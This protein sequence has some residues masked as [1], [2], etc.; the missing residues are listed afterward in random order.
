MCAWLGVSRS[1]YYAWKNNPMSATAERREQL[2]ERIKDIFADSDETYGY[3]RIHAALARQGVPAGPELVRALMRELGLV[4][5]QPRPWRLTTVPDPTAAATP[6]LVRRD[7]T[8]TAPGAKLVGDIT[9]IKT[10]EGW[11]YLATV[12]DCH[13][14]MVIGY[15]MADHMKT[16][17][18]GDAIDMAARNHRLPAGAIFHSDRGCQYTST[19]F[20]NTLRA[21]RIRP[22]VGRTG[23]CYDN[24][25]AES[26]NAS[27]KNELVHRTVFPTREHARRAIAP[28]IEFFYNRKRLHSGK[29]S[30]VC[31]KRDCGG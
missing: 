20:R 15:A 9:Y 12:I 17:L 26:F 7:F 3:R 21:L 8:A 2:K 30:A 1:G 24:A 27:L 16:S 28:Y 18:V 31:E 14:K 10:W 11:L 25:M 13:T 22:S 19:E 29:H 6:D 5:C 4:A 23:V